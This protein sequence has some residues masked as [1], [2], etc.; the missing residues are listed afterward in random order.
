MYFYVNYIKE[1]LFKQNKIPIFIL[2]LAVGCKT[3]NFTCEI[4]SLFQWHCQTKRFSYNQAVIYYKIQSQNAKIE[5]WKYIYNSL[6]V[7]YSI[8]LGLTMSLE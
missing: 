3:I 2:N 4:L 6:F 5:F 7:N 8:G 1:S